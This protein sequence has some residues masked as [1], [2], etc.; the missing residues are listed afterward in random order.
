MT[1]FLRNIQDEER[2]KVK[3]SKAV[4]DGKL[5]VVLDKQPGNYLAYFFTYFSFPQRSAK[6]LDVG[7]GTGELCRIFA[8]KGFDVWGV[9]YLA[10]MV[11]IA[12]KQTPSRGVEYG[13][14]DA[15]RLPFKDSEFDVVLCLGVFQTV[16]NPEHAIKELTRVL[17]PGGTL[18]VRTLN[19]EALSSLFLKDVM[20][21]RPGA[22]TKLLESYGFEDVE[23]RGIYIFPRLV[24]FVTRF[25]LHTG[26]YK[27]FNSLFFIFRFFAHS[28]YVSAYKIK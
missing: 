1:N 9:D 16:T 27:M 12:R 4:R 24:S 13:V 17:K 26:L 21:Y 11:E 25:I 14:A 22:F 6:V 3:S 19:A 2:W 18:I 10:E 8:E 20:R 15:Y 7:C 23:L 28:F 5:E